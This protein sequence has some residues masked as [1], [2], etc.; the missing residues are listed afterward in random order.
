M[1]LTYQTDYALRVLL[2]LAT[3]PDKH[4]ANIE[5]ISQI[6]SISNNHLV[7]IVHKLGKLG[8]L[9]TLRGRKGGI[10]LARDPATIIIG[11]VVRQ[12]EED[13]H[14][15]ECFDCEHNRCVITPVCQ[16]RGAL[17][18]ALEAFMR[19]LDNYTLADLTT[20]KALYQQLITI[21]PHSAQH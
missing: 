16:L 12:T 10:R 13:F 6:Y 21:S 20:N 18:E 14:I 17:Q 11:E 7:K 19:V 3:C 15:V 4:L 5:Q 1:R 9:K 2:Y 8:Y